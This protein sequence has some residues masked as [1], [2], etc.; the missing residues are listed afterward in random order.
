M[1]LIEIMVVL[2]LLALTAGL[3]IPFA[4]KGLDSVRSASAGRSLVAFLND[5]RT[6]AV[7]R[8]VAVDVLYDFEKRSISQRFDEE[9]AVGSTMVLPRGTVI[10]SVETGGVI[11]EEGIRGITFY[12]MGDSSGGTIYLDGPGGH[13]YSVKIGMLFASP[14]LA[15][16]DEE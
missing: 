7:N 5:A 12:P 15:R 8:G 6:R 3:A 14:Y 4:G 13:R 10:L 11:Y 16:I 9:G 1:T 2:V